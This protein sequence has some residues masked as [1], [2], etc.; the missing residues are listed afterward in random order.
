M[1]KRIFVVVAF[2]F[3]ALITLALTFASNNVNAQKGRGLHVNPLRPSPDE[4]FVP[5]RLLVSFRTDVGLDHAQQIIAAL[6]ARDAG[7]IPEIGIH[8]LDLPS[9]ASE[10]NAVN[11]F[12]AR[13]EVE[14]AEL[15]RLLPPQ[16]VVPNDPL[17]P[18]WF[19]LKIS[20]PDAWTITTGSSNIIIAI[21]DT[22]VEATHEDLVAKL[23]PG[24]NIYNN[25]DDTSDIYGHG[26]PVAG[27]A[28]AAS[29]NGLGVA[30][31]AWNCRIMPI[32]VS[33]NTGAASAS[34]IASGLTWAADHGARVA[35][36]S[37]YVTGSK[38]VSSGAK[39]FQS[40]GGVVTAASGNYGNF[41]TAQ[42]DPYIL[43]IGATDPQDNLYSYSSYGNNLDL[44]APGNNTTTLRGGLYGA[45]G[46]TSFAAPVV[47]GVAAL[48]FS[49]NP[50][51]TPA[52]VETILKQ[53]ADDLGDPGWDVRFGSGRVNAAR[54]VSSAPVFQD[55]PDTT[56]PDVSI[57]SPQ[58]GQKVFS[59]TRVE[60]AASDNVRVVKNELY[61]DDVL[62]S[63]STTAP[64]T[65]KWNTRKAAPGAHQLECKAYDA[66]GNVGTS[67]VLTVYK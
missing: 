44:V 62:V 35:N 17:Y 24:R 22:G 43:T 60:V 14:F 38:T 32:R 11:A 45:G 2:S 42:D 19:L 64:F 30:S 10:S 28:A 57:T 33:D 50:A 27:V 25:N 39:Y 15:D 47:A 3:I 6:G 61:A 5:G 26:T 7:E 65:T 34:D 9:G 8:V 56:P 46:G 29:N 12:Q 23:V 16:Q 53:N 21:L 36:V 59:T 37:Y 40:K 54:A 31:V 66:A 51:L 67:A 58:S 4:R 1:M 55:I 63:S 18:P 52:Q 13:P 48:I 49:V 20:A 41:E